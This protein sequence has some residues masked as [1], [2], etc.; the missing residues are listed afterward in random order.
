MKFNVL[1]D[2]DVVAE[3]VAIG[4]STD[5]TRT[6]TPVGVYGAASIVLDAPTGCPAFEFVDNTNTRPGHE[7][8]AGIVSRFLCAEYAGGGTYQPVLGA[9]S[10]GPWLCVLTEL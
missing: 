10:G 7:Q 1:F 3:D 4:W 8:N 2:G 6:M 5:G 9:Y